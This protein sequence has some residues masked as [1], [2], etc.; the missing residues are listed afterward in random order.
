VSGD[1]STLSEWYN[2]TAMSPA[3]ALPGTADT[4]VINQN[5][6][7]DVNSAVGTTAGIINVNNQLSGTTATLNVNAGGSLS[8]NG[9]LYIAPS[10]ASGTVNIQGGTLTQSGTGGRTVIQGNTSDPSA[11]IFNISSGTYT[12]LGAAAGDALYIKG[13]TMNISGGTIDMTGGQV[14][15]QN[16]PVF[17]ITGDAATITMDRLNLLSADRTSDWNFTLG[18][19]GVSAVGNN[20]FLH[21]AYANITVDGSNYTGPGGIIDLFTAPNVAS[22]AINPVT[23][24]GFNPSLYSVVYEDSTTVNYSRLNITAIPEPATLGMVVVFCSGMVFVRRRFMM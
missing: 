2:N 13:A 14:I 5:K 18:A 1:W 24:T 11:S 6:S 10:G 9:V 21:L 12:A 3:I 15:P 20:A 16:N 8:H 4:A 22:T 7:V 19:N 17:N 23:I